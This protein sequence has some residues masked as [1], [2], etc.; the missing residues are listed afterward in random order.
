MRV[1]IESQ[2]YEVITVNKGLSA[3][4]S[5][6]PIERDGGAGYEDFGYIV[7]AIEVF[8]QAE[9]IDKTANAVFIGRDWLDRSSRRHQPQADLSSLSGHSNGKL[10][11][12][13]RTTLRGRNPCVE[14]EL[15]RI[16][17][18]RERRREVTSL[19]QAECEAKN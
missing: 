1:P 7:G 6:K 15:D 3:H 14:E 12:T 8:K 4:G 18:C 16:L 2:G 13:M 5:A 10:V 19:R 11:E 17:S 9:K